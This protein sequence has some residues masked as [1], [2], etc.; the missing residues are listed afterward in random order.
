MAQK[1]PPNYEAHFDNG[2]S[3]SDWLFLDQS[4]QHSD[5]A[6]R[7]EFRRLNISVSLINGR[8]S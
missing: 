7:L 1:R 6:G 3:A 2:E 8:L 5:Q 4:L